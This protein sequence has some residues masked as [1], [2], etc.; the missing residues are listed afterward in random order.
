MRWARSRHVDV[1]GGRRGRRK[2]TKKWEVKVKY[3]MEWT[4]VE[5]STRAGE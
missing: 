5:Q 4:M 2:V 3:A 1:L